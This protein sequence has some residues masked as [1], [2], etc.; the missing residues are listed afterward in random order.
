M[1]IALSDPPRRVM[2]KRLGAGLLSWGLAAKYALAASDASMPRLIF[3][4]LRGGYDGLSAFYPYTEAAYY[5]ARPNIAIPPPAKASGALRLDDRWA[6]HPVLAKHL[7]G[8][9]QG[10]QMAMIPFCGLPVAVRSHFLAQELMETGAGPEGL[11]TNT[12]GFVNR[13][14]Q[15]LMGQSAA[16]CMTAKLAQAFYGHSAL[17]N[18]SIP[19]G[20]LPSIQHQ[21]SQQSAAQS[22][23]LTMYRQ[24]GLGDLW[25]KGFIAEDQLS[26]SLHERVRHRHAEEEQ[27]DAPSEGF[28]TQAA[29]AG[30]FLRDFPQYRI[31]W[32]ELDGWDTHQFQ[33]QLTGHLPDLF[34]QLGAG[35]YGMAYELGNAEWQR[36][37]VVV[38]SEFG[39]TFHEN[40]TGGTDHGWGNNWFMLGGSLPNSGVLGQQVSLKVE[41]LNEHRDLAVC[42]SYQAVVGSLLHHSFNLS[43]SSIR[44]VLSR[45]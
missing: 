32:L 22:A 44:R 14:D 2:L 1:K 36:T 9:W 25:R 40:G 16:I 39:R 10:K 18:V 31:G 45:A 33:G 34:E 26:H 5:K 23:L 13:L 15:E 28:L 29:R 17:P 19:S 11:D 41:D 37:S 43:A 38:M 4:F 24:H 12:T 7:A 3:V 42:N 30:R 6:M 27:A 35:L 20:P 8:F 21:S